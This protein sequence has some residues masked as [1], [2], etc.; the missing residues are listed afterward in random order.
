M[1]VLIVDDSKAIRELIKTILNDI[2][3][4]FE[5]SDG[6]EAVSAYYQYQPDLKFA[7]ENKSKL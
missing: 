1:Q 2:A 5:C 3:E 4:V 7:V 6:D